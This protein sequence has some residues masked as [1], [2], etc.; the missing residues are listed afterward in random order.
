METPNLIQSARF[1]LVSFAPNALTFFPLLREGYQS[2]HQELQVLPHE[3][4]HHALLQKCEGES[5]FL[6]FREAAREE[7]PKVLIRFE[8]CQNSKRRF[9]IKVA[10]LGDRVVIRVRLQAELT[11]KEMHDVFGNLLAKI[12]EAYCR[13]HFSALPAEPITMYGWPGAD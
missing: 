3:T 4:G 11:Q 10:R 12:H 5:Y 9:R 13:L 2:S 6:I 7:T 8:P 1:L